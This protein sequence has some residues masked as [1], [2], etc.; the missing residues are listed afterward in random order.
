MTPTSMRRRG[1]RR[2]AH[3]STRARSCTST[4]RIVVD[5]KIADA[6]VE[7]LTER[8][9]TLS[10]GDPRE[11]EVALEPLVSEEAANAVRALIDD[12]LGKGARLITGG[13]GSG[14]VVPATVLDHVTPAMRIYGEECFGP[15][16]IVL[17]ASDVDEAVRIANDC[18]YGLTAAVFGR[19]VVRALGGRA[20]DRVRHLPHQ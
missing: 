17:R 15:V 2:S 19:D 18:D 6:F 12:A 13:E 3:S 1:R 20:A 4:G 7:K 14:A 9:R 8:V 11:G 16:V 5:E 10:A